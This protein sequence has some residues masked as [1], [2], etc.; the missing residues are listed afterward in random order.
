MWFFLF[1]I[2]GS[3]VEQSNLMKMRNSNLGQSA[4]SLTASLVGQSFF[5]LQFIFNFFHTKSVVLFWRACRLPKRKSK[6][7]WN[8]ETNLFSSQLSFSLFFLFGN[9]LMRQNQ[10]T[11]FVWTKLDK[12]VPWFSIS[13]VFLVL[14]YR[15]RFMSTLCSHARFRRHLFSISGS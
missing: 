9:V 12:C 6:L 15:G 10:A 3:S 2:L 14:A 8:W 7:N 13:N 1:A 4:P 5:H 11:L